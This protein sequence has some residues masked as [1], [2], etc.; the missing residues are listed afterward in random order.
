MIF[1]P[2]PHPKIRRIRT[3]LSKAGQDFRENITN[4]TLFYLSPCESMRGKTLKTPS[5]NFTE[6]CLNAESMFYPLGD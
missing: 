3:D 1:H 4:T 6:G 2:N 5:Q